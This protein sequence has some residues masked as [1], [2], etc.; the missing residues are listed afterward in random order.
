MTDT[1]F[2]Y[3]CLAMSIYL[4]GGGEKE[5]PTFEDLE[6]GSYTHR[7]I[8]SDNIVFNRDSREITDVTLIDFSFFEWFKRE[9]AGTKIYIAPEVYLINVQHCSFMSD[10]Y[11]LGVTL[12][13]MIFKARTASLHPIHRIQLFLKDIVIDSYNTAAPETLPLTI[14]REQ[15][16]NRCKWISSLQHQ[17]SSSGPPLTPRYYQLIYLIMMMIDDIP[18]RR[19][20][21]SI[22]KKLLSGN[23]DIVQWIHSTLIVGELI[24]SGTADK[25]DIHDPHSELMGHSRE[26]FIKDT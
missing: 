13:E 16:E 8:K 17:Y 9:I 24:L 18:K 5:D 22:L 25:I 19:P 10:I 26:E 12:C 3:Q 11:S 4:E 15:L 1:L 7:D 6:S 23:I 2:A 20:T 14:N 21:P